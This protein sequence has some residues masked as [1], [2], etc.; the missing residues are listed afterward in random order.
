MGLDM[1]IIL[2]ELQR[3]AASDSGL[4]NLLRFGS[5]LEGS[6]WWRVLFSAKGLGEEERSGRLPE[7]AVG[8]AEPA[9]PLLL[10]FAGG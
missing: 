9:L 1:I 2:L 4:S 3:G 10:S 5:F 8:G 6:Q 7:V